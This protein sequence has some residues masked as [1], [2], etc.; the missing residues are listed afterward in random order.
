MSKR[1]NSAGL[2]WLPVALIGAAA[3]IGS[4]MPAIA[5]G[6][7]MR[8]EAAELERIRGSNNGS[9]PIQ[10]SCDSKN[11]NNACAAAGGACVACSS[12][13]YNDTGSQAG[14]QASGTGAAQSCGGNVSGSCAADPIKAGTFF[15]ETTQGQAV[16]Q[17]QVPPNAPGAQG[18][19]QPPPPIQ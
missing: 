5:G 2:R 15:C 3:L 14:N 17:C 8:I 7:R 12:G 13:S 6:A 11:L 16:G 18:G 4:M 1:N 9:N 19:R 10:S